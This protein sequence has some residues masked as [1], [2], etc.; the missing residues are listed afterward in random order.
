MKVTVTFS[1]YLATIGRDVEGRTVGFPS[2]RSMESWV[3]AVS[4]NDS[5]T[6]TAITVGK[7]EFV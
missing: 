1:K 4:K 7:D 6:I 5:I 3:K 2:M